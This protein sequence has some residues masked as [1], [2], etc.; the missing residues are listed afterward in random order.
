MLKLNSSINN[1]ISKQV[2][3]IT[4]SGIYTGIL[5]KNNGKYF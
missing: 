4:A 2:K 5:T 1:L 3:Y